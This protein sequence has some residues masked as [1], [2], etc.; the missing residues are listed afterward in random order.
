MSKKN[1]DHENLVSAIQAVYFDEDTNHFERRL[2]NSARGYSKSLPPDLEPD[3]D[4]SLEF[5][6]AVKRKFNI[7]TVGVYVKAELEHCIT[8]RIFGNMKCRDC[9][10]EFGISKSVIS[11]EI[12]NV[13]NHFEV[14]NLQG[15]K[16][17]TDLGLFEIQQVQDCIQS[18]V[19]SKLGRGGQFQHSQLQIDLSASLSEKLKNAGMGVSIQEQA[20]VLQGLLLLNRQ[21][22][23]STDVD[24]PI[25]NDG[26]DDI[27]EQDDVAYQPDT[28]VDT[29]CLVGLF[30]EVEVL[31]GKSPSLPDDF[32]G[33][34]N[35][36]PSAVRSMHRNIK[37]VSACLTH[38]K[39]PKFKK[40]S[41]ISHKRA[42]AACPDLHAT[43]KT[44]IDEMYASHYASGI[45]KTPRPL[46]TQ[47]HNG[48]EIGMDPN[49]QFPAVLTLGQ[50]IRSNKRNFSV[51]SGEKAPFWVTLFYFTRGDGA[52]VCPPC[53]VH[54]GGGESHIPAAFLANLPGNWYMH[55]NAAGYM[56]RDG[57]CNYCHNI[58]KHCGACD[59][60]PQ[61]LFMDGHD[62]HFDPDALQYLIDNNV[63]VFFLKSNDSI[64]DQPN[65][66]GPNS[67]FKSCYNRVIGRYRRTI[68]HVMA[69]DRPLFNA[70]IRHAWCL[71]MDNIKRENTIK[72]AFI[73]AGL[74]E[75]DHALKVAALA[76]ND[77]E[78]LS[79]LYVSTGVSDRI[80]KCRS[81]GDD[82]DMVITVTITK[83]SKLTTDPGDIV[84]PT[85]ENYS[86]VVDQAT[87][88]YF[89]KGVVAPT[90]KLQQ[91]LALKDSIAKAT[92]APKVARK[93]LQSIPW[94][95]PNTT[96][97]HQV[98][99]STIS[100]L[101]AITCDKEKVQKHKQ[102]NDR[103]KEVKTHEAYQKHKEA[104]TS[105]LQRVQDRDASAS[106]MDVL[107]RVL[108]ADLKS[109]F[110]HW[111]GA[112]E[113]VNGAPLTSAKKDDVALLLVP[114]LE[115]KCKQ[116][117]DENNRAEGEEE[118]NTL[119]LQL[120][121]NQEEPLIGTEV[122]DEDV[123][124]CI[125]IIEY[126]IE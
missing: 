97:G 36:N 31:P 33:V 24:L 103:E 124:T 104:A 89:E 87:H 4:S 76:T 29:E 44:K 110:I 41:A 96:T 63:F 22:G 37:R 126:E 59:G 84:T 91:V 11:R 113:K 116:R 108:V 12:L 105:I 16:E 94:T 93:S 112:K 100:S 85:H 82:D 75:D 15:L 62:S 118:P 54:Q 58:V 30:G 102:L 78:A 7:S 43:M 19:G 70:V 106:I 77:K 83:R 95:N 32:F 21:K 14:R 52:V 9:Y 2:V 56:D 68:G 6:R 67:L 69:L 64:N 42:A 38:G 88:H 123:P 23:S 122:A 25:D 73:K 107:K 10:T 27:H 3:S 28:A 99:A 101:V 57:S 86:L 40:T 45:L 61:Y 92:A 81:G 35:D 65:D 53:V 66:M 90:E 48:D 34:I 120:L 60:L 121:K 111:A 51:V 46:P 26:D 8:R 18:V 47:V 117:M 79:R 49:G 55:C 1:C 115:G 98:T 109:A 80:R 50:A 39:T 114:I 125:N 71:F 72:K 74:V 119:P 17:F 20:D 5:S 13:C